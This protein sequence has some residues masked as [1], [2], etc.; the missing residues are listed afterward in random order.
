MIKKC[1]MA[2]ASSDP[3]V[4]EFKKHFRKKLF[5]SGNIAEPNYCIDEHVKP[6]IIH[7]FGEQ[8]KDGK[9]L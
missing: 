6:S 4:S 9:L 3:A 1:L 8:N 5:K 2:D 7:G